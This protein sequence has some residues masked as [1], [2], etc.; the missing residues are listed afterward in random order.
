MQLIY[1]GKTKRCLPNFQ[2]PRTFQI[3]YTENP[4][5]NQTKAIEHF[6]K[7]IFPHLEKIKM[8]KG[9]LKEQMSLEGQDNNKMRKFYAKKFL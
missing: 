9:Y 5:F 3:T 6:E 4:W 1:P 2:F 8:Q 7:V